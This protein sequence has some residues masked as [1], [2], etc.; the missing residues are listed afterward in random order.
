[1]ARDDR[2][3]KLYRL[4]VAL[5][6]RAFR[7]R[8]GESMLQTFRDM[9]RESGRGSLSKRAGFVIWVFVET[10]IGVGREHLVVAKDAHAMK[11]LGSDVRNSAGIGLMLVAPLLLLELFKGSGLTNTS[12]AWALFGSLYLLAA[13]FLIVL[14][15]TVRNVRDREGEGGRVFRLLVGGTAFVVLAAGWL[16]IVADQLPCFLGVPYCD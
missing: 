14:T 12:D 5:Y 4:L 16:L 15:T 11:I 10:V 2:L 1:M 9:Q 13:A 6:P 3:N 7:A 8:F